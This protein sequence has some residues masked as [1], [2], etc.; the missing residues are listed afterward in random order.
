MRKPISSSCSTESPTLPS[1]EPAFQQRV[2]ARR[3]PSA[4]DGGSGRAL[5]P[6]VN[7]THGSHR[8]DARQRNV[9]GEDKPERA[10]RTSHRRCRCP[11]CDDTAT[12][13]PLTEDD[14]SGAAVPA[15][16]QPTSGDVADPLL[17]VEGLRKTWPGSAEPTLD[18]LDL[19]LNGGDVAL[20]TGRNGA[21][22]TTLLRIIGGLVAPES[23]SVH[24]AGIRLGDERRSYQRQIGL[25]TPGDR[26]LYA[27][28]GAA[29]PRPVGAAGA[30]RCQRASGRDE[31]LLHALRSRRDRRAAGRPP[32]DGSAAARPPCLDLPSCAD[33]RPPGRAGRPPSIRPRSSCSAARSTMSCGAAACAS[34]SLPR[35]RRWGSIAAAASLLRNGRLEPL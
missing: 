3:S 15:P 2:R 31:L 6:R 32:L 35:A 24:L 12:R 14:R 17:E 27:R 10:H 22:K 11:P 33:A 28:D 16:A 5:Q 34:R 9:A 1:V 21:G 25:L 8:R 18:D 7:A 13:M 29:Q 30:S 26:G 20:V 4:V 23:G 19:E